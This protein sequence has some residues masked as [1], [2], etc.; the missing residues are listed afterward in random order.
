M[1]LVFLRVL[2]FSSAIALCSSTQNKNFCI[3]DLSEIPK[4]FSKEKDKGPPL[5]SLT[6]LVDRALD[7]CTERSLRRTRSV[8]RDTKLFSGLCCSLHQ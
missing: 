4:S 7:H 6:V 5:K 8:S 3:S 1:L 2:N